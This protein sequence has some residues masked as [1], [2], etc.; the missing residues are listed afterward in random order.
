V[1]LTEI[2]AL[3]FVV[4]ISLSTLI[5]TAGLF[6]KEIVEIIRAIKRKYKS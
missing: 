5:M 4:C 1:N 6:H 2:A 3:V